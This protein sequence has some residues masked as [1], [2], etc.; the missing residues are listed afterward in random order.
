MSQYEYDDNIQYKR[1]LHADHIHAPEC[2][3]HRYSAL[4]LPN[5]I[6][7]DVKIRNLRIA[8]KSHPGRMTD[9]ELD[10]SDRRR[11]WKAKAAAREA[12]NRRNLFYRGY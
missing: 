1:P 9:E 4:D 3:L 11:K 12:E 6:P 7:K 8:A 10:W 5:G 2:I